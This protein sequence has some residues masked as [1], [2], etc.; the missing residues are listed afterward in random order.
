MS[1]FRPPLLSG[2]GREPVFREGA[3]DDFVRFS[4]VSAFQHQEPAERVWA[5]IESHLC[6]DGSPS[7]RSLRDRVGDGLSRFTSQLVH[8]LF[9]DPSFYE[10]LDERKLQLASDILG[11]PGSAMFGL[12]GA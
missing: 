11:W 4:L 6:A 7:G 3:F 2:S 10:R 5:R 1:S 12:A 9:Y 8:V